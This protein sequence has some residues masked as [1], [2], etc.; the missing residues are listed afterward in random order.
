[1]LLPKKYKNIF[2]TGGAGFI[3]SHIVD[4]LVDD[5]KNVTVFDNLSSGK[6]EF[7]QNV[8]TR[9]NFK[10]KIGDLLN[11]SSL[12]KSLDENT[13]IVFHLAA[14]P[15]ISKGITD[16]TIDFQQTIVATFNLL[17]EMKKKNIKHLVYFSGSGVYGDQ[18]EKYI[19]E[20]YG[21]LLPVSMYGASK[22]SAEGLIAAFSNLFGIQVW[23]FRPANIIGDRLTHGVIFDFINKLKQN[24]HHLQILGDGKQSKSYLYVSDVL[25]AVFLAVKRTNQQIHLFNIASNSFISVNDIAKYVIQEMQIPHVKIQHTKGKI[26]WPGDVPIVRISNANLYKLG[27][28]EKFSSKQAVI[29]TLKEVVP[30]EK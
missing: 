14:N 28:K 2:I 12:E 18:G 26:G 19:D 27:W 7:L 5:G 6:K 9:K 20:T 22:L 13:D 1:M 24:P 30:H 25:D 4:A 23:I 21:P 11:P 29:Q 15:D 17:Q 16:P 3:G 10:L 8:L